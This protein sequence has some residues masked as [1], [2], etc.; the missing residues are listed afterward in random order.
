M[1]LKLAMLA[2]AGLS[3]AIVTT[4]SSAADLRP[5]YKAPP[6]AAPAWSWSGFY[7]G[8]QGGAGS[9]SSEDSVTADQFCPAGGACGAVF[10]FPAPGLL[11]SNYSFNGLHGGV[12]AGYNWQTGPVLL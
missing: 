1:H 3:A 2:A 11:R 6:L 8:V 5:L 7:I 12:T 4:A 9:G 10:T